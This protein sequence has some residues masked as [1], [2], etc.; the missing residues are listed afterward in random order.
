MRWLSY[1]DSGV[2]C[3]WRRRRRSRVRGALAGIAGGLAASFTMNLFP[4]G[5]AKVKHRTE[6]QEGPATVK[7]AD[8]VLRH[9]LKQELKQP[10]GNIVHYDFGAAAGGVYAL[11][12]EKTSLARVGFGTRF[13]SGWWPTNLR[14]R[15]SDW[16]RGLGIIRSR[17]TDRRWALT[18]CTAR[19]RNW[20]GRGCGRFKPTP[21]APRRRFRDGRR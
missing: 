12:A 8:A 17:R 9:T 15:R 4:A 20:C 7:G 11:V 18:W 16:R 10:A 6:P 14:C 1:V 21:P 5:P 2:P 3:L 13:G 19:R